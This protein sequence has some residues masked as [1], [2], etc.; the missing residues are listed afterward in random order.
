MNRSEF[1]SNIQHNKMLD[2]ITSHNHRQLS[3]SPFVCFLCVKTRIVF[4]IANPWRNW[5]KEIR[6]VQKALDTEALRLFHFKIWF[7]TPH[8][9]TCQSLATIL[10]P[11]AP[12]EQLS[13]PGKGSSWQWISSVG[14]DRDTQMPKQMTFHKLCSLVLDCKSRGLKMASCVFPS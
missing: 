6:D 1:N 10:V 7:T 9:K 11:E 2:N 8:R 12:N 14:P 4:L 3:C 13:G 5:L